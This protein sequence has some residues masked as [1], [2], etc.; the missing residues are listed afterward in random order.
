M[1][2]LIPITLRPA[3]DAPTR[4]RFLADVCPQTAM[5]TGYRWSPLTT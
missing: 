4:L 3:F 2:L 5:T 1:K